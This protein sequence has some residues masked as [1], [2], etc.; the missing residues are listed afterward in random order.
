MSLEI[1]ECVMRQKM[2]EPHRVDESISRLDFTSKYRITD[3][4][5]LTDIKG[6]SSLKPDYLPVK[7]GLKQGRRNLGQA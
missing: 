7:S 3:T 2:V 5:H 4:F 1:D 6:P